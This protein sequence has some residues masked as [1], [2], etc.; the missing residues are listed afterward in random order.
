MK[1]M[2]LLVVALGAMLAG[3]AIAQE[4]LDSYVELL[5]SDIKTQKKA[6]LTEAVPFTEAEEQAFWPL[7]REYE[8]ELDKIADRRLKLIK[9]YA[10]NFDNMTNEKAEELMRESM[11]L[12]GDLLRLNEKYFKKFTKATS[13]ITAARVMQVENQI[14]LLIR[15][16]IAANLP[17][18][19]K[20]MEME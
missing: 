3:T 17:L 9:D 13:V 19:E 15:L 6:I 20:P 14:N 16:Q 1:R 18:V 5:R 4:G 2:L 12:D 11:Q 7:Y 10:E 8:L